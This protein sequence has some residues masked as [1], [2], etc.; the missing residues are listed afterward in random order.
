MEIEEGLR[1]MA[2]QDDRGV[3]ERESFMVV[4]VSKI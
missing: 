3:R 4:Q 2:H 1:F